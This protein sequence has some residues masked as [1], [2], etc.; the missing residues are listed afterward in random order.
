MENNTPYQYI[1]ILFTKFHFPPL[2]TTKTAWQAFRAREQRWAFGWTDTLTAKNTKHSTNVGRVQTAR[3]TNNFK[4]GMTHCLTK[5]CKSV[6]QEIHQEYHTGSNTNL[7]YLPTTSPSEQTAPCS[8]NENKHHLSAMQQKPPRV[9]WGLLLHQVISSQPETHV[10]HSKQIQPA[11]AL[12]LHPNVYYKKV[13]W[14]VLKH[15][16]H[17]DDNS[18]NPKLTVIILQTISLINSTLGKEIIPFLYCFV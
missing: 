10:H 1:N 7:S 11:H 8:E 5:A 16:H 17:P 9:H 2:E 18:I 13:P 15:F 12:H 4:G 3:S 6:T 14:I